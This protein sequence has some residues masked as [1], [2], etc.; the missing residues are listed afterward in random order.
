MMHRVNGCHFNSHIGK[1][2]EVWRETDSDRRVRAHISKYGRDCVLY[3]DEIE[4]RGQSKAILI[5][6]K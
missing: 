5:D 4:I 6:A 2:R 1:G 3:C